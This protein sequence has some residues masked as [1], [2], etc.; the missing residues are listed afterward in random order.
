MVILLRFRRTNLEDWFLDSAS[1]ATLILSTE[2]GNRRRERKI[3]RWSRKF[4]NSV[5]L[6]H[7]RTMLALHGFDKSCLGIQVLCDNIVRFKRMQGFSIIHPTSWDPLGP[8]EISKD[9]RPTPASETGSR[10]PG[11]NAHFDLANEDCFGCHEWNS[12]KVRKIMLPRF[13]RVKHDEARKQ[14]NMFKQPH[15]VH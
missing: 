3:N 15:V 4:I 13:C 5:N 6:P 8:L 2:Y 9:L 7:P 11:D 10:S 14:S 12:Q 1:S